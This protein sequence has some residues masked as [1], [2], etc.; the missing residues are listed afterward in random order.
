MPKFTAEQLRKITA[1]IFEAA[2]VPK[3]ESE[4]LSKHLVEANL[5]TSFTDDFVLRA[6]VDSHGVIRIPQYGFA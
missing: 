2:G 5:F 6:R 1:D 3:T 4:I